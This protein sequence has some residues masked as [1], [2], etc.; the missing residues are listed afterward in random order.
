MRR[1]CVIRLN[2]QQQELLADATT[3]TGLTDPADVL[4]HALREFHAE[5]RAQD[6]GTR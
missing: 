3:R 5:V 6:G 1:T 4:R 2:Q